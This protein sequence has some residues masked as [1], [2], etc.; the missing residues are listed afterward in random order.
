[1]GCCDTTVGG[2]PSGGAGGGALPSVTIVTTNANPTTFVV[3]HLP[4]DGA[5]LAY[6]LTLDAKRR[7]GTA[8]G[9]FKLW[10]AAARNAF[11]IGATQQGQI[12]PSGSTDPAPAAPWSAPGAFP[13]TWAILASV[14]IVGD[15]IT[16]EFS[17]DAAL[18]VDWT[19]TVIR[20]LSGNA[21][22]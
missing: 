13:A 11:G 4:V 21:T 3:A 14:N 22:I 20:T 2:N 12:G 6:E 8:Q 7:D 5:A 10:A 9:Y 19:F 1:M 17:G 16:F 15:A 18:T